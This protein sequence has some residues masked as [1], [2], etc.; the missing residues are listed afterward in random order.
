MAGERIL[1]PNSVATKVG[2]YKLNWAQN[3]NPGMSSADQATYHETKV[4]VLPLAMWPQS[5]RLPLGLPA[6]RMHEKDEF[7]MYALLSPKS[8]TQARNFLTGGQAET[9]TTS[10]SLYQNS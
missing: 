2:L 1:I 6:H 7:S 5:A 9:N 8:R 10:Q 3:P 4:V